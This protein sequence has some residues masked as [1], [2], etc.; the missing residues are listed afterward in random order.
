[1]IR[2][3]EILGQLTDPQEFFESP[4]SVA[5][6]ERMKYKSDLLS[7]LVQARASQGL[8]HSVKQT[9][10]PAR[11]TNEEGNRIH[12]N[13]GSEVPPDEV[14]TVL[15]VHTCDMDGRVP[16]AQG[17]IP[18]EE[19]GSAE[20]EYYGPKMAAM[21]DA[22]IFPSEKMEELLDVGPYQN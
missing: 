13:F 19:P 9:P 12:T 11:S 15:G 4:K 2:K 8:D 7:R 17:L 18:A 21:P 20:A 1:M 22:T 16:N 5:E 6:W 14:N 3:G 10:H